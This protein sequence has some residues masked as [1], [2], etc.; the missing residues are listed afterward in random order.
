M[1]LITWT[2]AS[3]GGMV[4]ILLF[5]LRRTGLTG[6]FM[7]TGIIMAMAVAEAGAGAGA[8]AEAVFFLPALYIAWRIR[9][10]DPLFLG[11][12]QFGL[13]FG[14]LN[15]ANFRGADLTGAR[16]RGANLKHVR[17][18]GV[19]NLQRVDFRGAK[20]LRLA[21]TKDT[22]LEQP[23]VREL[24]T[25]GEGAGKS[26]AGLNLK[27]AF[28]AG[29]TLTGVDFIETNLSD[30]DLSGADLDGAWLIRTQ[31]VATDL[32]G[33]RL[34]G[35][36][37]AAWNIDKTTRLQDIHCE[38]VFLASDQKLRQPDSGQFKPGEFSR[39][40]QE[41]AE[42]MDFI[43]ESRL[44]L[45]ALQQAIRKLREQGA[46]GLEIQGVTR[47]ED[48]VVVHVTAP[49]DLERERI[50]AEA[51]R[52]KD[53]E[54]KLLE[55][56]YETKL[57]GKEERIRDLK[58]LFGQSLQSQT[59]IHIEGGKAVTNDRTQTIT[60][61]TIIGST[62]NQGEIRER[63]NNIVQNIGALPAVDADTD[64]QLKGLVAQL[65]DTLKKIPENQDVTE[66]M[67][68]Q[69][70]AHTGDSAVSPEIHREHLQTPREKELTR[71][72]LEAEDR[73]KEAKAKYLVEK[74]QGDALLESL[75]QSILQ[76]RSASDVK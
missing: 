28:L 5:F 1:E 73:A 24:L 7:A 36:C 54:M 66:T 3:A 47:K 58:D 31:L 50:H 15:G 57:L 49:P 33:A 55:T 71:K 70:A 20:H 32:S 34:T 45:E 29:A 22:L 69:S 53:M 62:V 64:K 27:G 37:I 13:W 23:Q 17:L 19:S 42:T 25:S 41:V 8:G 26:Y 74:Q 2:V 56:K 11:V 30:A 51:L 72:I 35:A 63:I 75:R 9:R 44:E 60:N 18:A 6:I 14:S 43:V 48:A 76:I 65:T 38:Y 16:F 46:E 39:L 61:S 10:E 4:G 52:Q 59:N 21:Y 68:P 40:F 12:Q 67:E